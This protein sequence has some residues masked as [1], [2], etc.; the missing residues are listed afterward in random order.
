[1]L[2]E[3][4]GSTVHLSNRLDRYSTGAARGAGM[5]CCRPF[6]A[7][8]LASFHPPQTRAIDYNDGGCGLGSTRPLT[9]KEESPLRHRYCDN[10]KG[11]QFGGSALLSKPCFVLARSRVI[12]P[13]LH[14]LRGPRAVTRPEKRRRPVSG[15]EPHP[16]MRLWGA[17][18]N[19]LR[20]RVVRS[21]QEGAGDSNSVELGEANITIKGLIHFPGQQVGARDSSGRAN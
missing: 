17:L 4:E 8:C 11:K 19:S 3:G 21:A 15:A 6:S 10:Q 18:M 5:T 2:L 16:L 7:P 14:C 12:N 1:V 13:A 20:L 9:R